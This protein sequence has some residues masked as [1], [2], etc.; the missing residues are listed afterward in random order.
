MKVDIP[1]ICSWAYFGICFAP[2]GVLLYLPVGFAGPSL[3]H[4]TSRV[5]L[6]FP[7]CGVLGTLLPSGPKVSEE[8]SG[9]SGRPWRRRNKD[10]LLVGL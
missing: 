2:V 5:Q 1:N 9:S 4:D 8:W 3:R 6:L 7:A 10:V